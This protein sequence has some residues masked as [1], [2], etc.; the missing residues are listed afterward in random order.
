MTYKNKVV[1]FPCGI[2]SRTG[3]QYGPV[4]D[5]KTFVYIPSP[6]VPP[7]FLEDWRREREERSL[8]ND[9]VYGVL[10]YRGLS[11]RLFSSHPFERMPQGPTLADFLVDKA[12]TVEI[13][14]KTYSAPLADWSMHLDPCFDFKLGGVYTYGEGS[15]K[16]A[17]T[18]S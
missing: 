17:K 6:E 15:P 11:P 3:G 10:T 9:S 12:Y 7:E 16:K 2:E 1:M 4:F 18:L 5:D 14:G 13:G 8:T